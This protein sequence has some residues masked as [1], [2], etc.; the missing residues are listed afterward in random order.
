M[1]RQQDSNNGNEKNVQ[2]I[3]APDLIND[4]ELIEDI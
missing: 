3:Q 1:I 4:N 2:Q